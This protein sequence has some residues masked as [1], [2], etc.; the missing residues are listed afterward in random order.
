MGVGVIYWGCNADYEKGL[1]NLAKIYEVYGDEL[2]NF[3]PT[4]AKNLLATYIKYLINEDDMY[5]LKIPVDFSDEDFN[6][7]KKYLNETFEKQE[8]NLIIE[9][10]RDVELRIMPTKDDR[11]YGNNCISIDRNL[12]TF[13]DWFLFKDKFIELGRTRNLHYKVELDKA[14]EKL[15]GLKEEFRDEIMV[16]KLKEA[17]KSE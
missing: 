7:I 2:V 5:K 4:R 13:G 6:N 11:Y 17:N 16:L 9:D 12:S 1:K 10:V 15:A 8:V 3:L 14:K